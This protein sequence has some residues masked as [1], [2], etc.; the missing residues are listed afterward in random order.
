VS[1]TRKT[2]GLPRWLARRY[3]ID[4]LIGTGSMGKVYRAWDTVCKEFVALK[5]PPTSHPDYAELRERLFHE[6]QMAQKV[7]HPNVCRVFDL[8]VDEDLDLTLLSMQFIEGETLHQL[9]SRGDGEPSGHDRLRIAYELCTGLGAIHEQGLIHRD[10]KPANIMIDSKGRTV[11]LD[12]G[13]T[14]D[15]RSVSDPRSGTDLYMAPEQQAEQ[16]AARGVSQKSDLY[17]LGLVLYELFT[18]KYPDPRVARDG[19]AALLD[20]ALSLPGEIREGPIKP[21]L[22]KQILRC[23]EEDPERRPGS[24]EEVARALPPRPLIPTEVERLLVEPRIAVDRRIAWAGLAATLLGLL[25]AVLLSQWTQPTQAATRGEPPAELEVR[26]HEILARLGF[27]G[28]QKNRLSGLTYDPGPERPVRFW[29]RQSP[30]RLTP[31]RWGS[32]FHRY[33]DPPFSTPGEV[34][35]QLDPQG[36]LVRL[37]AVPRTRGD[38]QGDTDAD[39]GEVGE[40]DWKPLLTAAG[41]DPDRLQP[42]APE[43]TPPVFAD[44][45]AAWIHDDAGGFPGLYRVE[46]AALRGRPVAFRILPSEPTT[47]RPRA[48]A[49]EARRGPSA[50]STLVHDLGFGAVMIGVLWLAR[51]RLREQLADR[52]AAFRLALFV[53][54]ARILGGLFGARHVWSPL[55]LDLTLAVLSRA[56]LSAAM[57]WII[58]IA[59]EPWVRYYSVDLSASWIRLMYG[60]LR[61]PL[62]GRDLAV[63]GLFGLA[64]LSWARLY[65]LVPSW[66]GLSPPRLDRLSTLVGMLA[67]DE[68]E[69]QMEALGSVPR[70]LSM[71]AY[72]LVHGVLAAFLLVSALVL[73]RRALVF[74]WLSRSTGFVLYLILIFPEAGNPAL[75]LVWAVGTAA[76]GFTVLYRFGFLPFATAMVFAW[77]LSSHPLTL[78]P[79]SWAFESALVP[80]LLTLGISLWGFRAALGGQSPLPVGLFRLRQQTG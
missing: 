21:P 31:W 39:A 40:P 76:L 47:P 80:L 28:T 58:Y 48:N 51:R 69:L 79:G 26:A 20:Q 25:L 63:G 37:D 38:V 36:R 57:V 30:G 5:V 2:D 62:V 54:V 24:V 64:I 22:A 13:L 18:G 16:E 14:D 42:A 7:S 73:L 72:A 33:E 11:L 3:R 12:F 67:Q 53:F 59:V 34:G 78:D 9:L 27:D 10:L 60:R 77:V 68:I 66:L 41:L 75:D 15:A 32:A 46:A 71:G 8:T 17:S 35:I 6:V 61:D 19:L 4:R 74:P 49:E 52:P 55:E 45:R 29:Y 43:W 23:L 1:K 44:R 65:V 50:M 70:A 56:L